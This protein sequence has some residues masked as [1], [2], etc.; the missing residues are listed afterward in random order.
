[1][2]LLG[3]NRHRVPKTIRAGQADDRAATPAEVAS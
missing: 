1:V 3:H 2:S